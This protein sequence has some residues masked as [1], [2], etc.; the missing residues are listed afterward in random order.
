MGASLFSQLDACRA[1][2]ENGSR[3]PDRERE[4]ADTIGTALE[5]NPHCL[6]SV[7]ALADMA[8]QAARFSLLPVTRFIAAKMEAALE[9]CRHKAQSLFMAVDQLLD[10]DSSEPPP[11]PC[12]RA[13]G[14]AGN[15]PVKIQQ[16]RGTLWRMLKEGNNVKGCLQMF[17]V[18]LHEIDPRS[19][20]EAS[21][22][23]QFVMDDVMD[24]LLNKLEA[25]DGNRYGETAPPESDIH[26]GDQDENG[27]L[28]DLKDISIGILR[29]ACA[30]GLDPYNIPSPQDTSTDAHGITPLMEAAQ[31]GMVRVVD[32]LIDRTQTGGESLSDPE[33]TSRLGRR[34]T[35]R[36]SRGDTAMALAAKTGH[37]EGRHR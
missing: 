15:G 4:S 36:N 6:T 16:H 14:K 7:G 29:H 23:F 35:A 21:S 22:Q 18:E 5:T 13:H 28:A 17:P 32:F 34:L 20:L 26:G 2:F 27:P 25:L 30:G 19:N 24:E 12:V 3:D 8:R 9:S 10:L 31:H 1:I 37:F 33:W 11:P